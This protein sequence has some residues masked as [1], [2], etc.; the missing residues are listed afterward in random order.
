MRKETKEIAIAFMGENTLHK[1]RTMTDGICVYLH[2]NM[3]VGRSPVDS[4]VVYYTLAG[5]PT[6]TTRER[7][8]GI[9]EI[10]GHPVR[11]FQRK[12]LQW[13]NVSGIEYQ[14]ESDHQVVYSER[15]GWHQILGDK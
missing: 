13:V 3:I 10:L 9:A 8:N 14:I 11:F 7:L 6:T 5:W 4:R 2:G 15:T 12:G 1:A